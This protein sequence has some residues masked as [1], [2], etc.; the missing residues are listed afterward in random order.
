MF[1]M[2]KFPSTPRASSSIYAV[3]DTTLPEGE[4][5]GTAMSDVRVN[6][7]REYQIALFFE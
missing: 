1:I 4:D 5:S 3:A 2:A 7:P 6:R